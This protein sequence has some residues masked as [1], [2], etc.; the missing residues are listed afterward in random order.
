MK[1]T[2]VLGSILAAAFAGCHGTRQ[3]NASRFPAVIWCVVEEGEWDAF[4]SV[5]GKPLVVF[6]VRGYESDSGRL[7]IGELA[8]A[9]PTKAGMLAERQLKNETDYKRS[10]ETRRADGVTWHE[11]VRLAD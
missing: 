4:E 9:Q 8:P 3:S 6:Y 11:F 5:G 2:F 10:G 7:T 1:V